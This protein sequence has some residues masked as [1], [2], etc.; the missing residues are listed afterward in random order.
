MCYAH[1]QQ[2]TLKKAQA[3]RR[4]PAGEQQDPDDT[5]SLTHSEIV[6][7]SHHDGYAG[8]SLVKR[9]WQEAILINASELSGKPS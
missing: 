3:R 6:F 9:R 2:H 5:G 4:L 8:A 7:D 1:L